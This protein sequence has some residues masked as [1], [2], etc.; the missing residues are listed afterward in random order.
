[1]P[2]K[3]PGARERGL[4]AELRVLRGPD[5]SVTEAARRM[6]W[7]KTKLSNLENGKRN[8]SPEEVAAL[9]TI[10][11]VTDTRRDE[12]VERAKTV[13]ANLLERLLPGL[14]QESGTL[15][16]YEAEASRITSWEPLLIPG[17]LQ[18]LD[19]ARAFMLADGLDESEMEPRLLARLRR[20]QVLRGQVTYTALIGEAALHAHVGGPEVMA[21]QLRELATAA[22]RPNVTVRIVPN[23]AVHPGMVGPFGLLEFPIASPVTHV[24]MLR[25]GVFLEHGDAKPYLE[26]ADRIAAVAMTATESRRLISQAAD[27]MGDDVE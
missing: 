10:Y 27:V 4:G 15:A 5:L 19:Y 16:S 3:S 25:S 6:G 13:E 11:G 14:P 20:Q 9:C 7:H 2:R 18:T 17:L 23:S 21:A 12:L 24:E 1:M 22:K 8:I 26:A